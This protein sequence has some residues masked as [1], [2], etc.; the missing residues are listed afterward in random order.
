M[1]ARSVVHERRLRRDGQ[2]GAL[3]GV[4]GFDELLV[5]F[6][7]GVVRDA[8]EDPGGELDAVG[9]VGDALGAAVD[10]ELLAA[11]V[12]EQRDARLAQRVVP[13][14]GVALD[15]DQDARAVPVV[16]DV[17]QLRGAVL[18]AGGERGQLVVAQEGLLRGR[19]DGVGQGVLPSVRREP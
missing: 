4:H 9:V 16:D 15:G 14:R 12:D 1:R 2:H 8:A 10:D 11:L 5:D 13:F 17:G 18:A 19:E 7:V 6:H 3:L